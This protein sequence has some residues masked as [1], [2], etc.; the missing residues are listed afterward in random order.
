MN[1][2]YDK[3]FSLDEMTDSHSP[4]AEEMQNDIPMVGL[5]EEE[6]ECLTE[7][8][9]RME[10]VASSLETENNKI[11]STTERAMR[12]MERSV[13]GLNL[14]MSEHIKTLQEQTEKAK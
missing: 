7:A 6:W 9:Y 5:T 13:R 11:R 12:E 8:I 4:S 14:E 2:Q 3:K 10:D 1:S